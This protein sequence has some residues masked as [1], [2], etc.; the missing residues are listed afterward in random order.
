MSHDIDV[1]GLDHTQG[2]MI[3][4]PVYTSLG[5]NKSY[6]FRHLTFQEYMAARYVSDQIESPQKQCEAFIQYHSR[7]NGNIKLFSGTEG[8]ELQLYLSKTVVR[9]S[10][11][12][13]PFR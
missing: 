4:N 12:A 7:L 11:I 13:F 9:S 1:T 10:P 3:V 2:L 6:T 5:L 8:P